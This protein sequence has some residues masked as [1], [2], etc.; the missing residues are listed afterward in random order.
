[1]GR[2][3]QHSRG[4]RALATLTLGVLVSLVVAACSVKTIAVSTL[5][6]ALAKGGASWSG[7]D[8]PEL[9]RDAMPFA[10]KTTESLLAAAPRHKGLLL[11]AASSFTQYAYAFVQCDADYIEAKDLRA[12]IAM[13]AR[14]GKLYL[15]ARNYGMRGLEVASTGFGAALRANPDQALTDIAAEDVPLLYWTAL[16]WG[17]Q[18]AL[19]KDNSDLTAD[20]P[21]AERLMRRARELDPSWGYGSIFDFYIAYEGG[22]PPSAGGSVDRARAAFDDAMRYAKGWRV[23]PLVSLAESVAVATQNRAEFTLLLDQALSVDAERTG[24]QRLA[25]LIAQKRAAWLLSR[26]DELFIE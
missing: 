16:A 2:I 8:D 9:I 5:G 13:R 25:N 4:A 6:N 24:D 26:A 11:T 14:A 7:D 12:A 3:G 1:M 22:R 21:L 17:A 18:I 20:L 15:R 23:A 10:L 19:A